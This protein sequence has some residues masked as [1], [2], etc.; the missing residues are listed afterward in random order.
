MVAALA[1]MAAASA[2]A[3]PPD[4][5]P[6]TGPD[7]EYVRQSLALSAMSLAISRIA[8]QKARTDDIREFAMLEESEQETLTEVLKSASLQSAS[9]DGRTGRR[10]GDAE[11]EQNLDQR[12]R[13]VL[14]WLR[15]EPAGAG[16]DRAYMGAVATGHLE[17]LRVHETYLESRQSNAALVSAARLAR[18][19]VKEHIQL[20]TDIESSMEG[21]HGGAPEKD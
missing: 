14:E 2:L 20:L 13:Q 15:A 17:Q 8:Q 4:G 19:I 12:G 21:A 16:F 9:L 7:Q 11:V 6:G 3:Q 1:A 5:K 10:P 18:G